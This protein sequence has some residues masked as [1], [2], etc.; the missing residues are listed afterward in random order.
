ME[1]INKF[2]LGQVWG[3]TGSKL[4]GKKSGADFSDNQKRFRLFCEAAIEASR[5]LPFGPG[6]QCTFIAN[7][8]HSGLVPVLLKVSEYS[9]LLYF[10]S[11]NSPAINLF[12]DNI[13]VVQDVFQARGE[14][15]SSKC[16][17]CLHNI[18]FQVSV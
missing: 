2:V 4:Y 1:K 15:A 13:A 16:I 11:S 6:E 14:F 8:W 10:S 7:D 5:V 17:F 18:A 3:K 12:T 9:V